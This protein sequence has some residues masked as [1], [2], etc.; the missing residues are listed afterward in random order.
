LKRRRGWPGRLNNRGDV[1][2]QELGSTTLP[3]QKGTEDML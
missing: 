1:M 2:I 3:K